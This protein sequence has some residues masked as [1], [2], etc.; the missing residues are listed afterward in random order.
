MATITHIKLSLKMAAIIEQFNKKKHKQ[1]KYSHISLPC[2]SPT[3]VWPLILATAKI[4]HLTW[5][6]PNIWGESKKGRIVPSEELRAS[7][8]NWDTGSAVVI[9][10]QWTS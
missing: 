4:G 9:V 2:S 3:N 1:L 10:D 8:G 7:P 5:A 6:K